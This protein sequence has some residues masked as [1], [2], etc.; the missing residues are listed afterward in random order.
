L[1]A[2]VD[3]LAGLVRQMAANQLAVVPRDPAPLAT[4]VAIRAEGPAQVNTGTVT[5]T[6][7]VTQQV[8][9]VTQ[10]ISQQVTQ[11]IINIAPWDSERRLGCIG[12]AE[13]AAAFAENSRL[14]DYARLGDHELA[15]PE[16]APPYVAELFMDLTKRAHADP[17]A[18]NIYLNPRRSD[19]ALVHMTS[20]KWE[21]LPLLEATRLL[22]DG[23]AK[24]IHRLMMTWVEL[25]QLPREAQNAMSI[26]GM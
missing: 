25:Q 13:V 18:R 7:N 22:F 15:D 6:T 19:Q 24:Q 20:G 17:A 16:I 26:A 1:A 21:V 3:E 4:A 10:N 2:K 5:N 8:A 9:Q 11:N 23:V 12:V 14:K